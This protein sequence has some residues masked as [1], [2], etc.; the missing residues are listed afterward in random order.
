MNDKRESP[1]LSDIASWYDGARV[2]QNEYDIELEIEHVRPR[3]RLTSRDRQLRAA[4]ASVSD[5][6]TG[7]LS[8]LAAARAENLGEAAVTRAFSPSLDAP[9]LH[10][11]A[12]AI[13][14]AGLFRLLP[15]TGDGEDD[16]SAVRYAGLAG[17]WPQRYQTSDDLRSAFL[18]PYEGLRARLIYDLV[19]GALR[20][21]E[22]R[23]LFGTHESAAKALNDHL[24]AALD[25][26][27]VLAIA[28]ASDSQELREIAYRASARVKP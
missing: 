11:I 6:L 7:K 10:V 1:P 9:E 4:A 3:F 16:L 13:R 26:R 15:A 25:P 19:A 20:Q 21:L 24:Q 8:D 18:D 5:T 17:S 28:L 27:R 12:D 22:P 2:I 23:D 14:A